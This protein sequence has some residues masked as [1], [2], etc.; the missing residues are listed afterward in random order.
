MHKPINIIT[1]TIPIF[2]HLFF[3]GTY[4]DKISLN[5]MLYTEKITFIDIPTYIVASI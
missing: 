2:K 3:A 4:E 5:T 1:V